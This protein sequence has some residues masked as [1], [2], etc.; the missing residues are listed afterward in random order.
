MNTSS[1]MITG[2]EG[3]LLVARVAASFIMPLYTP[4]LTLRSLQE[5]TQQGNS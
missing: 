5:Y 2:R 4:I 3:G 1:V